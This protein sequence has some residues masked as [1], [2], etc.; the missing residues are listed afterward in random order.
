MSTRVQSPK[1]TSAKVCRVCCA[2]PII[3]IEEFGM[4]FSGLIRDRDCG[5]QGQN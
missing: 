3:V 4:K 1:F 2:G 5:C